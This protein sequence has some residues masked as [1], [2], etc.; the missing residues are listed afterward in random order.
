MKSAVGLRDVL[1]DF[2]AVPVE[3]REFIGQWIPLPPEAQCRLGESPATGQ[4][5]RTAIIGERVT[6][7]GLRHTRPD[8][9]EILLVHAGGDGHGMHVQVP[10]GLRH[11]DPRSKE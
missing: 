1:A 7:D 4:L 3:I 5:G 10:P 11:G 9:A 6:E 8:T 2:L